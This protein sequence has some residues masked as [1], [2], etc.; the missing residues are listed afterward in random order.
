MV[1]TNISGINYTP[2]PITNI[3]PLT[4]RDGATFLEYLETIKQY[5]NDKLVPDSN[6]M[7]ANA[8][9]SVND[10]KAN[11]DAKYNEIMNDLAA[12]IALL[13]ESAV[14]GMVDTGT[15]HNAI[16]ALINTTID[17]VKA[18]IAIDYETKT[19]AAAAQTEA[20]ANLAAA[21]TEIADNLAG[22]VSPLETKS[23]VDLIRNIYPVGP[24]DVVTI[25]DSYFSGYQPFPTPWVTPIPQVLTDLLNSQ[26]LNEYRLHNYANNAGGYDTTIGGGDTY[27]DTQVTA[28]LNDP[29]IT[30]CRL[31]VVGGGRNDSNTG[32]DVYDKAKAI[33][34]RLKTKW[35]KAKLV[36]FPMWTREKF[37]SGQRVTF[38]SIYRAAKDVGAVCDVNSLWVN[39][40]TTEDMWIDTT[41]HPKSELVNRFA[42][43]LYSLIQGG[44]LPAQSTNLNVHSS[45]GV[46]AGVISLNGLEVSLSFQQYVGADFDSSY[47]LGSIPYPAMY[48]GGV[49]QYMLGYSGNGGTKTMYTISA[50][51]GELF[52]TNES[53]IMGVSGLTGSYPL[54]M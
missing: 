1:F 30:N 48:P 2:T 52:V 12:Q 8:I 41:L 23:A 36:V 22:A 4:Y 29:A 25:G 14:T 6:T 38:N 19:D 47:I 27:F 10:V 51:T 32:K 43:A 46:T 37:S 45:T 34:N 11:W 26:G 44:T 31:I 9:T 15:V 18:Q 3:S 49:N 21:K 5:I 24:I 7:I 39:T 35:P 42:F 13:N 17:A 28:A 16:L 54:G 53:G 20:A 33:Y 40:F 50:D